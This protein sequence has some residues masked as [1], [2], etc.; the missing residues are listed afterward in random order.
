MLH[1]Q[2]DK[3]PQRDNQPFLYLSMSDPDQNRRSLFRLRFPIAEQPKL[4]TDI[5]E[6]QVVELAENSARLDANGSVISSE[7]WTPAV[8][9]LGSGN[10]I[11][12]AVKLS[13]IDENHLVVF[14]DQ[15]IP[16]REMM[17]EQQR[18]IAKYGR[19]KSQNNWN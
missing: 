10:Q 12:T 19:P 14:L 15:N 2:P 18:L 17:S 3:L 11:T 4:S 9:R 7:S 6:Y 5:Q 1:K 8:L 16:H 13:R